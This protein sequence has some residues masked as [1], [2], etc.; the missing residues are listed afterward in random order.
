MKD[1]LL[2]MK[3]KE[4]VF[5]CIDI[6]IENGRFSDL[7][8]LTDSS[9]CKNRFDMNF[10]ILQEVPIVGNIPEDYFFDH[11]HNRRYYP[12]AVMVNN[13]RYIVCNDWYYKTRSTTRDTRTA[14]VNW[15]LG[16]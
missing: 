8:K 2:T 3:N 4:F 10:C 1:K 14:F 16:Y 13:K 12:K 9:F 6:L 11:N 7:D 5:S 15:V